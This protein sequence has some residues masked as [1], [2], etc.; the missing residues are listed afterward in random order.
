[1][2]RGRP[3]QA[4]TWLERAKVLGAKKTVWGIEGAIAVCENRWADA[5]RYFGLA[6][7]QIKKQGLKSGVARSHARMYMRN[8]ALCLARLYQERK[9]LGEA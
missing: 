7:A 3:G 6:T 4:R 2:F 1:V 9:G 8:R 5:I